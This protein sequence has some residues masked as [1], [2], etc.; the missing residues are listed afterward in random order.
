[1]ALCKMYTDKDA[2][3]REYVHPKKIVFHV[4]VFHVIVFRVIEHKDVGHDRSRR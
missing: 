1:M 4:I 3:F 2:A